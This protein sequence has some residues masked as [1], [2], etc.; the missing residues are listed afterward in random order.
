[1]RHPVAYVLV[2]FIL[3]ACGASSPAATRVSARVESNTAIYPGQMFTYS[4]IVEGG[5]QIERIDLTPL[6]KFHP[7]PGLPGSQRLEFN[8]QVTE[9]YSQPYG[10][11]AS[12]PGT[13]VLPAVT[14]VVGGKTYTTNPVEV[15]VSKPGVTD[16]M[17]VEFS[18]SPAKGYVGQPL[19]MKVSW[20]GPPSTQNLDISVPVFK[21]NDFYIEDAPQTAG[22]PLRQ[23]SIDN[24]PVAIMMGQ[25]PVKGVMRAVISFS[26][27][28]IPKR[29][30]RIALDPVT[31]SADLEA[32]R[33][34][35]ND[36]VPLTRPQF[37]HF[38]VKSQAVELD[39]QA[40]PEA[41]KP[42][43]F[44]GLVGHYTL[45]A[46][47]A[48]TKVSV[49]D[50]ITLT[51]RIGGSPYLKPVQ[52]PELEKLPGLADKFKIPSEKA[53]PTIEN[54]EK[55]FTQTIRATS[56]SV[57]E[58]PPISL[59]YFDADTGSYA[60]AKTNPI[61]LE[62]APTKVLTNADVQG[63]AG[64]PVSRQVEAAKEGSRRSRWCATH[65]LPFCGP[66]RCWHLPPASCSNWPR[67][68]ATGR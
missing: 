61:P 60:V 6:D 23:A 63:T 66:F 53:S 24:V 62:V 25:Q 50:P 7:Q 67:E 1:M 9:F 26:K 64:G 16:Q 38:A 22:A 37:Q 32:G 20:I 68:P 2:V 52:W 58:I 44:Y 4:I 29:A 55:V 17:T 11:V 39:I 30:G 51:I 12:E 19:V 48:P 43:E 35:L 5:G 3:L 18:V 21:S 57:K 8:G 40:M 46:S 45:S 27:V 28:L 59:A 31:T 15:T 10:I 49:G 65:P 36:L 47:A 33:V 42:A 41:G 54:G 13:M 56:D 14:V 34:R